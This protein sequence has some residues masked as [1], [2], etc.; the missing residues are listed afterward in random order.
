MNKKQ[1][2]ERINNGE[3]F[4]FVGFFGGLNARGLSPEVFSNF[5]PANFK[6][7][8]KNEVFNFSSTEQFFMWYKARK[9]GDSE[10]ADKIASLK[11]DPKSAKGLG[12]KVRNY[13]DSVWDSVREQ[14]M[15]T[16]VK[17]K[18]SQNPTLREY[19]LATG[20]SVLVEAS[21]W[22]KIWGCG[23]KG[24]VSNPVAWPGENKLGFL[25][26]KLRDE[27]SQGDK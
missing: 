11:Y 27:L 2:I 4:E 19:L 18:F 25:L 7:T 20:D 12:R 26:M 13:D 6:L 10:I 1:L 14:V 16:G 15:Y 21:P 8:L 22:D 9:F 24:D 5:Y 23:I 3:K 17:L